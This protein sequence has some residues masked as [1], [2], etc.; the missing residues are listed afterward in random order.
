MLE[1][2]DTGCSKEK[3]LSARSSDTGEFAKDKTSERTRAERPMF[4]SEPSRC[5]VAE[6]V[7]ISSG[8]PFEPY[9]SLQPAPS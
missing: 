1:I 6:R 7:G 4:S 8:M 5:R 9:P 3:R 2:P